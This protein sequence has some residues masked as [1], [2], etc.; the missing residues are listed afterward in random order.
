L[1]PL[2][3]VNRKIQVIVSKGAHTALA[4]VIGVALS[5][6]Q[7]AGQTLQRLQVNAATPPPVGLI[8]PR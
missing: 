5:G 7:P 3:Q 6:C 4:L 8:P 1:T 2:G